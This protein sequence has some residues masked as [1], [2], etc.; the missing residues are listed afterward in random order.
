MR[1]AK[2]LPLLDDARVAAAILVAAIH[3]SPLASVSADADF[4]LT[5][6]LARLAVPFFFL[7]TGY[8]L[9]KDH[10]RGAG[11]F[12]KK[13]AL[14]YLGA[15]LLYLPLNIYNGGF[16]LGMTLTKLFIDGTFYHLWYFPAVILGVTLVSLLRRLGNKVAF[17]AA[18]LL[19]LVGLGGDS[20]YGFFAKVPWLKAFYDGWFS[21]SGYT[22]GGLFFAPL[23]LLLGAA[24]V[25][26]RRRVALP[27]F[28]L[29][30]VGMTAEAFWLHQSGVQHHDS[31][32]LLLPL[33]AVL[34]FSLLFG[35]NAG[36]NTP[37]RSFALWFYLLHPW[38]IVLVRGLAK[39]VRLQAIL[40]ENSV[41]YFLMVLLLGT[42]LSVV[43]MRLV[44]PKAAPTARA[45]REI[46]L[47]ALRANALLLQR[48]AGRRCRLMAVVKADAYGHG[49][50]KVAK[51]LQKQGV[52]AFAVASLAEGIRL[53]C[54]GI[55]GSILILGYT[56][57]AQ[58]NALRFWRLT[59][60]ITDAGYAKALS[61][62]GPTVRVHLAL[63]T[64]MH[65]LG[66]LAEEHDTIRKVAR[67]P[68]LHLCGTF[69]HLCVSDQLTP[70]STAYTAR[71]MTLFYDTISWM[72][73]AGLPP[74]K[75]HIQ[76]SYGAFN[77]PPQPCDYLRAGIALYGVYSDAAPVQRRLPLQPVLTLRAR[78]AAVRTLHAGESAGYG[79]MFTAQ[80]ETQ[81]L[82]VAIG[83]A[84][85]LP[86]GYAAL[87]GCVLLHGKRLPVV[88]LVC[89]DQLLVDA[90]DASP[91]QSGDIVTVF[92]K[93]GGE[94]LPAQQ[95][96]AQCGMIT[97]E[98]L[99]GLGS[100]L[101]LVYR[102]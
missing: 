99:A 55:W 51:A 30:F 86:R 65:R 53:R 24:A 48:A 12:C 22:R 61:E 19:Y 9:G 39:V 10:W 7:I 74:G 23:F 60:T 97:N 88:G 36:R 52:R 29:V 13:M 75:V 15:V 28:L 2:K 92:G 102:G 26:L 76:A 3:T 6:V 95:V 35:G 77:L 54:A 11:A 90:T 43:A 16:P 46:D 32:Y 40:L 59:Q 91:V 70:A 8:F 85:G 20:Y 72:R 57:P 41:I 73:S 42:L 50:G 58:A 38:G 25:R 81:L 1:Q 49:A 27:A 96:A 5:R 21:I 37:A 71:Q 34:L 68:H 66:I 67:L 4:W 17:A 83:Y 79:L 56:A 44:P 33:C 45:W 14:L 18:G 100:R 47:A 69:S 63:D 82:T 78:V 89:M 62:A 31:M 93:E 98:L 101:G 80:R 64:G 94:E 84:D 87:G